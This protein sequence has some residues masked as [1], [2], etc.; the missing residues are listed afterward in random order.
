LEI[1]CVYTDF[2]LT[3]GIKAS[4]FPTAAAQA[5]VSASSDLTTQEVDEQHT[6]LWAAAYT[7]LREEK[8]SLVADYEDIMAQAMGRSPSGL[9]LMSDVVAKKLEEFKSAQWMLRWRGKPVNV[10]KKVEQVV[11][12]VSVFRDLG[13]SIAAL[14]PIHAGLPWA[15]ICALLT[16]SIMILL[17]RLHPCLKLN[18]GSSPS[19]RLKLLGLTFAVFALFLVMLSRSSANIII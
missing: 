15:G 4:S 3:S 18:M 12:V 5:A 8:C 10:R 9:E 13:T 17:H 1:T 7:K 14:D 2:D 16:V 6:D 19:V 11:K